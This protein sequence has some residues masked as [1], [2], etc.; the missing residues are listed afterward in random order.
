LVLEIS[1]NRNFSISAGSTDLNQAN[2][3]VPGTEVFH[4]NNGII[5]LKIKIYRVS[6][7]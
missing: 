7:K 3:G 4:H 2:P 5:K 6:L 1:I